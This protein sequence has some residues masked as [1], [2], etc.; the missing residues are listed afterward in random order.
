MRALTRRCSSAT[1]LR[2]GRART[3]IFQRTPYTRDTEWQCRGGR[4]IQRVFRRGHGCSG[5]DAA[6]EELKS[7]LGK[8]ET[9]E[10]KKSLGFHSAET[11]TPEASCEKIAA[12]VKAA[13]KRLAEFKPYV[14]KTPVTLE[15]S[16][17]NY[18]PAEMLSY[19]RS[20]QRVDSHT[21][22]FVGKDMA[23]VSDFLDVVDGY[24]VDLAP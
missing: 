7:R 9:A 14:I 16:F 3:H 10:T 24:S 8:I 4:R 19:L 12:G 17:K 15:I 18:M 23:E 2:S 20:V 21:I 1:T 22:R 5:D 6:V 11:I 13:L